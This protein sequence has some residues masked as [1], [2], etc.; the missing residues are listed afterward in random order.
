MPEPVNVSGLSKS[1]TGAA[2]DIAYVAVG[3]G[4]LGYQRAQVRRVELTRKLPRDMSVDEQLHGVRLEVGKGLAQLDD[5]VETATQFVEERMAPVE[6]QLPSAVS[7][8]TTKALRHSREVR[9][10]VRQLV[11]IPGD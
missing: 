1:V 6:A 5:L 8:L 11:A 9:S 2:R 7:S 10:Q 4:V 3:L